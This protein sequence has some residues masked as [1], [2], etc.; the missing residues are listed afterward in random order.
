MVIDVDVSAP[1]NGRES[2][3]SAMWKVSTLMG[4]KGAALDPALDLSRLNSRTG[5]P[6]KET[7]LSIRL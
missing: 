4:A 5:S 6:L 2:P 3:S 1:K 7:V